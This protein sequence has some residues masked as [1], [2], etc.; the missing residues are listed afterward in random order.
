[1]LWR[2]SLVSAL[3]PSGHDE[4]DERL[5]LDRVPVVPEHRL[6]PRVDFPDHHVVVGQVHVDHAVGRVLERRRRAL[7]LGSEEP[8]L[9]AV[10]PLPRPESVRECVDR[11]VNR[12]TSSSRSMLRS[13]S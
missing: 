12:P 10:R 1:M 13:T 6:E 9:A 8:T 5:A 3:F 4:V 2:I 7:A 11:L